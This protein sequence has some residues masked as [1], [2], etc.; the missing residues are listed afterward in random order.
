MP[1]FPRCLV[2]VVLA[3]MP[4]LAQ[5]RAA[6][7]QT[8]FTRAQ[9]LKRGINASQWFAQSPRDYSAARTDRYTDAADIALI[10]KL[11]FD[12]VRLS[13]DAAPLERRWTERGVPQPARQGCGYDAGRWPGGAD[14]PASRGRLQAA[15]ADEQ[16]R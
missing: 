7:L 13:V 14:R 9:H 16:R 6:D 12:N 5:N 8:A 4:A 10:A 15:V 2:L 11:G 1:L 3:A